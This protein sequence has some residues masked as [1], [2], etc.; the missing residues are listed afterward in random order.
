[1]GDYDAAFGHYQRMLDVR[2]DLASYS[3]AAHLVFLTGD[4]RK[5]TMLMQKAIAAGAPH[6]ENTAWCRAQLALMLW[7][8]GALLPAEHVVQAGLKDAPSNYHLLV[9]MG[10]IKTART[11]YDE[12]IEHYRRAIAIAPQH[13]A[14]VA[15]GDLYA[16]TG[17]ADEAERQYVLVEVIHATNRSNGVRGDLELARFYADHDRRVEEALNI[18]EREHAQRP[19]VFA[20]D[21]LAW[22]Q[23]KN[24]RYDEALKSSDQALSRQTPDASFLFHAGMIRERL[25]DRRGAQQ[26]LHRALSLNPN[27]HPVQSQIAAEMLKELGG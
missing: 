5:A 15:L 27:F 22:S 14:V 12:A 7:H 21:T 24:G 25:G 10:R 2:P 26:F 11:A 4:I 19:N 13:E 18:A 9:A 23:Y 17:R 3:R 6:A 20:A 1:M 16:L 8:T